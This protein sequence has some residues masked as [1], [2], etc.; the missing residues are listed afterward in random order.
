M[1]TMA[2][3]KFKAQCLAVLDEVKMKRE[4]VVVT[5]NGKPYAKMVPLDEQDE[6]PLAVFHFGQGRIVGDILAPADELEDWD[7]LK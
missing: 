3:G 1:K 2:A 6:D 7:S 4:E 5:K